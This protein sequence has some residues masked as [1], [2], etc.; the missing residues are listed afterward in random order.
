MSDIQLTGAEQL[1]ALSR[2]FK[3]ENNKVMRRELSRGLNSASK[4]A[5][6]AAQ[7]R[8]RSTLPKRGGLA[9]RVGKSRMSTSV[10]SKGD[11]TRV[12]ILAKNADNVRAINAGHVRH[13]VFAMDIWVSQPVRKG[14]FTEPMQENRPTV[15][16]ELQAVLDRI[17]ARL[18]SGT[19]EFGSRGEFG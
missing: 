9:E 4:P 7:E 5:R 14:W 6:R 17:T 12:A 2:R 3:A 1:A 15:Q 13:P 18:A 11:E 8:A 19:H 10:R 16:R